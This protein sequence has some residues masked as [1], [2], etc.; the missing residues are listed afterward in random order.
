MV[1][2]GE[3]GAGRGAAPAAFA[4]VQGLGERVHAA[5]PAQFVSREN[6]AVLDGQNSVQMDT[7]GDGKPDKTLSDAERKAQRDVAE[8]SIKAN[9]TAS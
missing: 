7:D 5:M 6:L 4:L 9:C 8:A 2:Q 1:G 3:A